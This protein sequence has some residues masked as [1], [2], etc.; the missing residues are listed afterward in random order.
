M[1]SFNLPLYLI[2]NFC[3]F[4]L[5]NILSLFFFF[6]F[7]LTAIPYFRSLSLLAWTTITASQVTLLGFSPCVPPSR[8]PSRFIKHRS[9][10]IAPILKNVQWP[11]ISFRIR[12]KIFNT[13]HRA[14]C[15]LAL[16]MLPTLCRNTIVVLRTA[17][18]F[19]QTGLILIL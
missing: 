19:I 18:Q 9:G 16:P 6:Y 2:I 8:S 17:F 10:E 13:V 7:I 4:F 3:P 12:S 14:L 1:F 15:N 11:L 5:P